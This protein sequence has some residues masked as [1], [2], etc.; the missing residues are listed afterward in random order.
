MPGTF[1]ELYT[2]LLKNDV[3][4]LQA[5][6]D[7]AQGADGLTCAL[8]YAEQGKP[9]FTLAYLLLIDDIS[10]QEKHEILA[11]SY[12]RRATISQEKAEQFDRQF[13]RPF[14]LIKLEAQKDR[15]AAQ[16]VRQGRRVRREGTANR[17]LR[18]N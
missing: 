7:M 3:F 2:S 18:V 5:R 16:Q 1:A 14:P 11:V 8:A 12:E 10:E 9:E 17:M 6:E 15:L 13:H 4:T